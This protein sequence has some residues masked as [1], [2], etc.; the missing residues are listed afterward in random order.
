MERTLIIDTPKQ[1][2]KDVKLCGWTDTVRSHG[3]LV[4]LDLRDRSGLV[5]VVAVVDLVK[6]IKEEDVLEVIGQVKKRPK[7]TVNKNIATGVIE[8]AAKEMKILAKAEPLPFDIKEGM[9]LSLPSL[10]DYRSLTLRNEKIKAIFKIEEEIIFSFRKTMKDLGFSEFQ[11]PTIVP[12]ATEGGAEVFHIDYY[13]YD[14]YLAQSPQLYK[15]IMASV[16]ERV[17]TLAH[18]YRAEPSVTTRHI[19]EYISLDAE[20]SFIESWEE[21][22]DT[23]ETIIKNIVDDVRKNCKEELAI[24]KGELPKIGK[25]PRIK[26]R[27]AQEIIFQ[28]TK[29]DHRKEPDLDPEDEKEICQWAKE[30][31][32]SEFIFITHYPTKKRPFYTFP[33]PENPEY[34]LSF[35]M[36]FRGLE[37]VTGGQR[38]NDYKKLLENVKKWGN[39]PESFELYLQA[40]K[41]GMPPEGGFAL[42]AERIVKQLLGLENL[43]EANLFPRDMTRVD[44][45]LADL[46]DSEK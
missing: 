17:F 8:V 16:F 29:R 26:M 25:I 21:L 18:A 32:G 44:I 37:I 24:T 9:N 28:R 4:F 31:Q 42:G 46:A 1:V 5:Q 23:C 34:T 22:L 13:G 41:Y 40:F 35:D 45:R 14:C 10:L 36:L 30:E 6:D 7:T 3:K 19:A 33:D 15:Q 39:K 20:M 12:V 27:E 2:G 38:I 43:R 11:A